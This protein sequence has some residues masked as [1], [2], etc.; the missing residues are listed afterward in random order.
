MYPQNPTVETLEN[1]LAPK[2]DFSLIWKGL[3]EFIEYHAYGF[4]D[5]SG[6]H[7][8]ST[9]FANDEYGYTY[10]YP[11]YHY[12]YCYCMRINASFTHLHIKW[13]GY[14]DIVNLW[15]TP[16]NFYNPYDI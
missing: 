1:F 13:I 12:N 8:P 11:P 7:V 5:S 14:G 16:T 2:P 3:L 6:T 4:I 10:F 9:S 15:Q